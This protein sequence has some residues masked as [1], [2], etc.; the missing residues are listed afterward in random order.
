MLTYVESR[1]TAVVAALGKTDAKH[2]DATRLAAD[3][4][5][6]ATERRVARM[7]NHSTRHLRARSRVGPRRCSRRQHVHE[8][9][10]SY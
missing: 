8:R 5:L 9:R 4:Q 7:N 10:M 1:L 3:Y 2:Q 6:P